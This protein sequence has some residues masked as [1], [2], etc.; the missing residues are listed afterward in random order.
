[1]NKSQQCGKT[2]LLTLLNIPVFPSEDPFSLLLHY[3]SPSEECSSCW[4]KKA[5]AT[6]RNGS[7]VTGSG[8]SHCVRDLQDNAI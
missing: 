2:Q 6:Q 5:G 1:M 8:P 3:V 7:D 4:F